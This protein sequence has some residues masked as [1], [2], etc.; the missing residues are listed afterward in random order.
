MSA[1]HAAP[2]VFMTHDEML[3]EVNDLCEK[4]GVTMIHFPDSRR[5]TNR[6]WPD[7]VLLGRGGSLFVEVKTLNDQLRKDQRE[8]GRLLTEA[9]HHWFV[10][11]PAELIDGTA[12]RLIRRVRDALAMA[13]TPNT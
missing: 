7:L 9:G 3:S 4:Y 12:E 1:I 2:R 10:W 5:V 6:G 11:R 13:P 8:I